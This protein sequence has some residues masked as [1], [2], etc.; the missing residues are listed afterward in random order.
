[1]VLGRPGEIS[2]EQHETFLRLIEKASDVIASS[3]QTPSLAI[4]VHLVHLASK[5]STA[6]LTLAALTCTELPPAPWGL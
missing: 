3:F 4:P 5:L 2:K 1:M 6:M